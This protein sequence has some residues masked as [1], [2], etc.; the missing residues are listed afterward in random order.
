V[1]D[2]QRVAPTTSQEG[3]EAAAPAVETRRLGRYRDSGQSL[4]TVA[5]RGTIVNSLYNVFLYGLTALKGLIVAALLTTTEFGVWGILVLALGTLA[6][7]KDVGVDDKYIQQDEPD[8]ELAFKKAF[9]MHILLNAGFLVVVL[10]ALPIFALIYGRPEIILP[11]LALT[12]AIPAAVLHTPVWVYYREMDYVRQRV[13]QAIEPV[14]GFV[15]TIALAAAGAGYWSLVWGVVAGAWAY[16]IAAILA[17]PY[18]PGWEYSRATLRDYTS[19]SRPLLVMTLSGFA[20][21]QV[22]LLVANHELGLAGAGLVTFAGGLALYA[23]RLDAIITETLY[24][25]ICA[26]KDRTDLLLESFVKSNRIALMWG[27]PFGVGLALFAADL[28]H[29][30]VGDHWR[31]AI[32]LLQVWGVLAAVNHLGFNWS[33]FFRARGDTRPI[34]R[35]AI[36]NL[37]AFGVPAVFLTRKYGMHGFEIALSIMIGLS[38]AA[39]MWYLRR[40]FPD[41][42][43]W[44]HCL[45]AVAPTLPALGITLAMRALWTGQR[46]VAMALTELVV[47]CVA[48]VAFTWLFERTLVRE[49]FGYL[50]RHAGPA[51]ASPEPTPEPLVTV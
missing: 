10:V 34:G 16:G 41:F 31:G 40:L 48:T 46:T 12:L 49:M 20:L 47:Y 43:V 42:R 35:V 19:F 30:G 8:Q 26:V 51:V 2:N 28:V 38:V 21:A 24:P 13:F 5:A 18:K 32:G 23:E 29:F 50:R 36:L 44:F 11:G 22:Y 6:A 37:V 15:V 17:S 39:R 14:V 1:G 9:T 45:R 25:A 27:M 33:A 4:R 7:I 3:T